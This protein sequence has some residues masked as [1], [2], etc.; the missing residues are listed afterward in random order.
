MTDRL[1]QGEEQV[2]LKLDDAVAAFVEDDMDMDIKFKANERKADGLQARILA[3]FLLQRI[4]DCI[5]YDIME[6][7]WHCSSCKRAGVTRCGLVDSSVMT[8]R[9]IKSHILS[10]THYKFV[11]DDVKRLID[12]YNSML[13]YLFVLTTNKFI[14]FIIHICVV[15]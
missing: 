2:D 10:A 6:Y 4:V 13:L 8:T 7:S 9:A 5:V 11:A 1:S 12:E 15:C 3:I 14:Q